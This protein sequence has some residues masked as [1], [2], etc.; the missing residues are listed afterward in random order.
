MS[1]FQ[2][3]NKRIS[4][5]HEKIL[6]LRDPA[7]GDSLRDPT[8]GEIEE[9]FMITF[10]DDSLYTQVFRKL[11]SCSSVQLS[12]FPPFAQTLLKYPD[13]ITCEYYYNFN[14]NVILL[15]ASVGPKCVSVLIHNAF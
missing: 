8:F 3:L 13:D 11:H 5:V 10:I 12:A 9:D 14:T 15:R 2:H 6:S 7:F 1:G 4:N